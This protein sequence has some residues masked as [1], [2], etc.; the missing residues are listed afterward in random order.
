MPRHSPTDNM[1]KR[2][3]CAKWKECRHPWYIAYQARGR[4]C[5]SNLDTLIGRHA[6]DFADA[7]GGGALRPVLDARRY[8]PAGALLAPDAYVFGDEIG[9]RESPS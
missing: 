7:K 8:G 6:A 2:C 4:R 5:R 9:R 3:A 1:H